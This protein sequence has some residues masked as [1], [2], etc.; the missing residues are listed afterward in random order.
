[1]WTTSWAAIDP[2]RRGIDPLAMCQARMPGEGVGSQVNEDR[3]PASLSTV[4]APDDAGS[5]AH[6]GRRKAQGQ[7]LVRRRSVVGQGRTAPG[8]LLRK[9]T[10]PAIRGFSA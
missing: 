7:L 6:Y 3:E 8:E 2:W 1:M 9:T 10:A 4:Q 5:Q